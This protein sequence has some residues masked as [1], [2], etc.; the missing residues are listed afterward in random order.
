MQN[1]CYKILQKQKW[2]KT[3]IA[4]AMFSIYIS[5]E[6][7]SVISQKAWHLEYLIK[8]YGKMIM[9]RMCV[10]K[11]TFLL[12][13]TK[14]L[15]HHL[16]CRQLHSHNMISK[17]ISILKIEET[18]YNFTHTRIEPYTFYLVFDSFSFNEELQSLQNKQLWLWFTTESSNCPGSVN[19]FSDKTLDLL[20]STFLHTYFVDT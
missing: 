2:L 17:Q 5:Y 14:H 13:I 8:N 15:V 20:G 9:G 12:H 18:L 7:T 19:W 3:N 11:P 16:T 6:V 4:Q 10:W 1:T